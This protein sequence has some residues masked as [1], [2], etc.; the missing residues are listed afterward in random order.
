MKEERIRELLQAKTKKIEKLYREVS[1]FYE[2]EVIHRFRTSTKQLRAFIRL[3]NEESKGRKF[4]LSNKFKHGYQIAGRIRDIQLLQVK[5]VDE[6][7]VSVPV[8]YDYLTQNL[9]QLKTAWEVHFHANAKKKILKGKNANIEIGM[10]DEQFRNLFVEGIDDVKKLAES[11]TDEGLH[12]VRKRIKD[13]L[14]NLRMAKKEWGRGIESL[15]DL[16]L[17]ELEELA[18]LLG[19]FNDSSII[20]QTLSAFKSP[21]IQEAEGNVLNDL[22]QKEWRHHLIQKEKIHGRLKSFVAMNRPGN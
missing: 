17:N 7:K 19:D 21:A 4:S 13:M 16:P 2:V 22:A 11:L 9:L 12:E 1:P 20:H 3:L 8:F 14:Y 6:W 10:S 5:I 18:R 15:Q